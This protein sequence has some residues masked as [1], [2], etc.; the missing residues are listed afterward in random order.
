MPDL[1]QP[2]VG[3]RQ[4]YCCH[5]QTSGDPRSHLLKEAVDGASPPWSIRVLPAHTRDASCDVST[6]EGC[7]CRCAHYVCNTTTVHIKQAGGPRVHT[8]VGC[9]RILLSH[10]ISRRQSVVS[11]GPGRCPTGRSGGAN[12]AHVRGVPKKTPGLFPSCRKANNT[13]PTD[14]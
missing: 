2:Q 13:H 8:V 1:K 9:G 6:G 4:E 14:T 10:M 11:I 3:D 7:S 5:G 12:R